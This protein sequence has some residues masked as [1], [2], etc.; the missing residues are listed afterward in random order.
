VQLLTAK[1]YEG[2]L[3][4]GQ[5]KAFVFYANGPTS[6]ANPAGDV[7]SAPSGLYLDAVN[8]T[9]SVSKLYFVEFYPSSV[10][11][12]RATWT[13]KY[14]VAA[15][16]LEVANGVNLSAEQFQFLAFGGDF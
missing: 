9:M 16:A 6:Y 3:T 15:T 14:F 12:T 4:I 1:G 10:G 7:V 8:D 2:G 11:S 13:A 5:R